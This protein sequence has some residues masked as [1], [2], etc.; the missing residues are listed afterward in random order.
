MSI[1]IIVDLPAGAGRESAIREL[2]EKLAALPENAWADIWVNHSRYPSIG[3]LVSWEHAYL[4][5]Y[6]FDCDPGF[7]SLNPLYDD[8]DEMVRFELANGQTDDVPLASCYPTEKAKEA[9]LHFARTG[10]APDW[11]QWLN[12]SR[13]G[14]ASPNDP[15]VET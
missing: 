10:K 13:D 6:R 7:V 15:F 11:L 12:A 5:F 8:S 1:S 4:T 9:L 2:E 14:N 3:A